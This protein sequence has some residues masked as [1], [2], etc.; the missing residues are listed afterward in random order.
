MNA[1]ETAVNSDD[2]EEQNNQLKAGNAGF[3]SQ[4]IM[5]SENEAGNDFFLK[6]L[7]N[8]QVSKLMQLRVL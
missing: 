6:N 7:S 5:D 8:L 3:D 4:Q 2:S 1:N